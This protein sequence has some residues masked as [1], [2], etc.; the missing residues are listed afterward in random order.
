MSADEAWELL[1]AEL[2]EVTPPCD[3]LDE[4]TAG[5]LTDDERELCE[6]ICARCPL[7]DLCDAYASAARVTSGFWAGHLWTTKGKQPSGPRPRGG[8]PKKTTDAE[9]DT[10]APIT[11]EGESS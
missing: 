8:R 9:A 11:T 3:G 2:R 6:S 5:G 4:F 10:S 1:N 7:L